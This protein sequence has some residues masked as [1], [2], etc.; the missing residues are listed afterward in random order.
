MR[1]RPA[2]TA[3][4]RR[5]GDH[6]PDDNRSNYTETLL[7]ELQ[8]RGVELDLTTIYLGGGLGMALLVERS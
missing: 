5:I 1:R 8:R 3:P 7:H 4:L 2:P 6:S